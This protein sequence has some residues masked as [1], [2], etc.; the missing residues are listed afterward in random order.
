M[1]L[2]LILFVLILFVSTLQASTLALW[3]F[4]EGSGYSTADLSGNNNNLTFS[5]SENIFS[6]N[7][8]SFFSGGTSL[9]GLSPG[10]TPGGSSTN[11]NWTGNVFTM[12]AWIKAGAPNT[13]SQT[14]LQIL[15]KTGAGASD[16]PFFFCLE[17]RVGSSFVS[18]KWQFE[19]LFT[20][21]DGTRVHNQSTNLFLSGSLLNQWV[22]LAIVYDGRS[23]TNAAT[24]TLYI[25]GSP[26]VFTSHS[27]VS[28]Q[29]VGSDGVVRGNLLSSEA[30]V[31]VGGGQSSAGYQYVPEY[32]LDEVRISNAILPAGTGSG[33]NELAFNANLGVVPE[34]NTWL[35]FILG[36]SGM[37]LMKRSYWL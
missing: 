15:G 5:P 17:N 2:K 26:T 28:N 1:R 36:F 35:I 11:L 6:T 7:R 30:N 27:G 12:E 16:Q 20:D 31:T 37:L 22:H 34:M 8:P 13:T 23:T 32:W 25:N 29:R 33:I 19:Y 21:Q 24:V 14:F 18:D 4:N 9:R 3:A 10:M